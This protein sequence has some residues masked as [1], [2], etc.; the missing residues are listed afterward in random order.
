[1]TSAGAPKRPRGNERG[2]TMPEVLVAVAILTIGLLA[3][4]SMLSAGFTNVVTSGGKS[5]ATSYARGKLEEL[6]NQAFVSTLA[7]TTDI[8]ETDVTRT[9]QIDPVSGVTPNRLSRITVTVTWATGLGAGQQVVV[10]T[11]RAE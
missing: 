1:M 10:E 7:P 8:P 3:V 6:K 5:K 9:W 4:V 2:M 11:V